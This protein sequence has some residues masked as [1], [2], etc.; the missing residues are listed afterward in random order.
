MTRYQFLKDVFDTLPLP[1]KNGRLRLEA[2]KKDA[3]TT[4]V[5]VV[6]ER[7]NGDLEVYARWATCGE[8]ELRDIV[9]PQV[10]EIMT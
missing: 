3:D 2:S 10:L 6:Q 4:R 1:R 5:E 9:A 8:T 7:P